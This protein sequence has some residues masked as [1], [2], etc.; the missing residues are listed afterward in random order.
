MKVKELI[1]YLKTCN[2]DAKVLVE[3]IYHNGLKDAKIID[4]AIEPELER[5][6]DF[7]DEVIINIA[8]YQIP[9]K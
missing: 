2:P 1:E 8:D 9:D 5:M 3:A 6:G 4:T 7:G